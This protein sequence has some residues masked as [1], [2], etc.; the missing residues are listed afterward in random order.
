MN[1]ENNQQ[2]QMGLVNSLKNYPIWCGF[3]QLKHPFGLDG[4][5]GIGVNT[6]RDRLGSYEQAKALGYPYR[7]ISFTNPIIISD[8]MLVCIDLDWKRSPSKSPEPEQIKLM[9]A[10]DKIG[11]AYETSLSS[12]GAHYWIL[13]RLSTIP[14]RLKLQNE[15][16]IEIFSGLPGQVGNVLLTDFDS[17][18][19]LMP[20]DLSFFLP[21]REAVNWEIGGSP[22]NKSLTNNMRKELIRALDFISPGDYWIWLRV[23]MALK[24]ELGD[25]GFDVWDQWSCKDDKYDSGEM[26]YKWNSFNSGGVTA[27]TLIRYAQEGG[28]TWQRETVSANDDFNV[29][30]D[31]DADEVITEIAQGINPWSLRVVE[32]T[33]YVR[34]TDWVIDDLISEKLSLI[35]GSPGAGKSTGLFGIFAVAAGFKDIDNPLVATFRRKILWVSEHPEQIQQLMEGICRKY[36]DSVGSPLYSKEEINEWIIVV[37]AFRASLKE[38]QS[39]AE[40]ANDYIV[41]GEDGSPVEPL[42]VLDTASACLDLDDENNNSEVGKYVSA[43]K[44]SLIRNLFPVVLIAHTPKAVH[45][46]EFSA[47]TARGAGAFEGDAHATGFVFHDAD[48]GQVVFKLSKRRYRAANDEIVFQSQSVFTAAIDRRGRSVPAEFTIGMPRISS[49]TS[50]AEMSVK[51][52]QDKARQIEVAKVQ[53][54]YNKSMYLWGWMCDHGQLSI[55]QIQGAKH[56]GLTEKRAIKEV[57]EL[58]VDDGMVAKSIGLRNGQST[59]LYIANKGWSCYKELE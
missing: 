24:Y 59:A 45:R 29:Y 31:S 49:E 46:K 11:A 41:Y 51:A 10:L 3:D 23:G 17:S 18:G 57:L 39:L 2:T 16:E 35:A 55:N 12:F 13:S 7:G 6:P 43:I 30:Y 40:F 34:A 27:G 47:L 28:F 58:M 56:P 25:A 52:K 1:N 19:S 22:A 36:V 44:E 42:I 21:K 33:D 9:K 53:D 26:A 14:S 4:V 54:K 38:L 37:E 32:P 15:C 20:V 50:R 8:Q 5:K 48:I